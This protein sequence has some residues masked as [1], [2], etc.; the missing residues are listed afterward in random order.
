M[1]K[2]GNTVLQQQLDDFR[3]KERQSQDGCSDGLF[4]KEQW[5]LISNDG[6]GGFNTER[7]VGSRPKPMLRPSAWR[8]DENESREQ[9]PRCHNGENSIGH[10]SCRCSVIDTEIRQQFFTNMRVFVPS[11][12][13]QTMDEQVDLFLPSDAPQ[14]WDRPLCRYF[15]G[16]VLDALSI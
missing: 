3:T 12:D 13:A 1:I 8:P 15:L 7:G 14:E 4:R 2:L 6:V 10:L 5:H 16:R 11:L 9:C